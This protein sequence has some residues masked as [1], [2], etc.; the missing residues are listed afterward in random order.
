[1]VVTGLVNLFELTGYGLNAGT[2]SGS[3][4]TGRM[5]AA[6]RCEELLGQCREHGC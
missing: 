5:S 3:V 4:A 2:F 6:F 1:M